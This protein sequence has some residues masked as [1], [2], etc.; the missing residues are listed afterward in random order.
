MSDIQH[1]LNHIA[2]YE[3]E[4][5]TWEGR[6]EKILKRYRDD[7]RDKRADSAK[8]NVLWSN[9]QTL[10]AATFARL[11]MPDVSRRFK[12]NDPVGRVASLILER[13]LEFEVQHFKDYG[14]SIRQSVYDRFLGGRGVAWVRYEVDA[15]EDIQGSPVTENCPVDYVHWKDFG[16]AVSRTWEELPL[17]WRKVYMTRQQLI[18]RFGEETAALLPLDATPDE[19]NGLG[20]TEDSEVNKRALIY[21][22]WDKESKTAIWLSKSINKIIDEKPDP[23]GLEDFFPCPPPLYST[24]TTDSLVPIPDFT[25]YQDQANELDILADRIDGLVK[26]LQVKGVYDAATPELARLFTEAGNGDLTPVNNWAAFAEKQGLKGGIDLVDLTPIANALREAY[27]AFEQIKSQ[28]YELT[29]IS[30]ILRGDTQASETATAQKIKN[31]YA[32]MRL[33]T[34][35]DEVERF[36]SRLLQIKAQIICAH[37]SPETIIQISSADQ[38]SDADKQYIGPAIGMLKNKVLRSF[39][40]EVSTDSM[41]Y[42]DE[43]QEKQDRMEFLSATSQFV[44]KLVQAG[45]MAPQ[46]IPL[47]VEMLK[48]GVTGFRVGKSLEGT[49]DQAA[50]QL[51]QQQARQQANPQP[52]PDAIKAQAEAQ[53]TQLTIQAQQQSEQARLQADQIAQQ[54]KIASDE[55]LKTMQMQLDAEKAEKDRVHAQMLEQLKA[56]FADQQAASQLDFERWKVQLE[57]ETKIAVAQIAAST[58]LKTAAMSASDDSTEVS[59]DGEKKPSSALQ[60]LVDSVNQSLEALLTGHKELTES[61]ASMREEADHPPMV[62]RDESGR[63][64]GVQR[65]NK[66]RQ[67]ARDEAGRLVGLQ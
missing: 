20:R 1:Y 29:G 4:F 65:G 45:Q 10:K 15:T 35:Q 38:L 2:A 51:K 31:S 18:E 7:K 63:A 41:V 11:P 48:F 34:Y 55:R 8:F 66:T 44:E 47:G 42:Q 5:K 36:A 25:L 28:I 56:Q 61:I 30:D 6:A 3:R 62:I 14:A 53:K 50:E 39:R 22:L 64:I 58:S 33:K 40:V 57:N 27:L 52:H 19:K 26:A 21:E 9:V 16:H 46:L 54:Q 59:E 37:Y 43:A 17:V 60:S 13:A 12:D 32:S 67:V 24:L 23:L 49:I